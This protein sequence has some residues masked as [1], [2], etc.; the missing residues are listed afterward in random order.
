MGG[1]GGRVGPDLVARG[2][3]QSPVEFA[4]TIWN[5]APAMAAAMK[6]RGITLP[7]L[8]PGE[9]ADIVA[10]LYSVR[11][12]GSAGNITNGWAVATQ[13]GCLT[14]HAVSGERGK[15]ASDLTK[16]HGLDSP[17]A[18]VASLWNHAVVTPP[19]VTGG[20]KW[21]WP[22]F[23]P[24]GD[25]GPHRAAAVARGKAGPDGWLIARETG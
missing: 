20:R 7:Q 18:V 5:K 1:V 23:K 16:L 21:E 6:T 10:Y 3:R 25:G 8:S 17:A 12:F 14:C 15:P 13:K 24:A 4:T 2:V 22:I 19:S 11:Y 9:M